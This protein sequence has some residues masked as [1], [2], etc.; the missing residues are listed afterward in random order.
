MSLITRQGADR[1]NSNRRRDVACGAIT[2]FPAVRFM[3]YVVPE[4]CR[5]PLKQIRFIPPLTDH[6]ERLRRR[7]FKWYVHDLLS[8]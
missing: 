1:T 3:R 5:R 2:V 7:Y 4:M 8:P 6:V